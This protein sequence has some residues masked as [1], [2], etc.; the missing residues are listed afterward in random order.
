MVRSENSVVVRI[1]GGIVKMENDSAVVVKT[2]SVD[3][4]EDEVVEIIKVDCVVVNSGGLND[5]SGKVEVSVRFE[6]SV[7]VN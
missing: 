7:V 6:N 2:C 3:D 5:V 4:M 1:G